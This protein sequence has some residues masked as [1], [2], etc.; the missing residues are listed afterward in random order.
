MTIDVIHDLRPQLPEI[1]DQG[2]RDTCLAHALSCAHERSL[3][4]TDSHLSPEFLH[5]FSK[6]VPT[7]GGVIPA[8]ALK[9]LEEYG[10]PQETDCPYQEREPA[11]NWAPPTGLKVYTR[12][13]SVDF[14]SPDFA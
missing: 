8:N 7:A 5:H 9:A 4:L 11:Q 1:R 3:G 6:Y 14:A 2:N 10:Q 12:K 13:G